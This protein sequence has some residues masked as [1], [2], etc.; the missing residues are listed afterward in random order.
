MAATKTAAEQKS[1]HEDWACYCC[2][3]PLGL[4]EAL[5]DVAG[6]EGNRDTYMLCD[7]CGDV[8]REKIETM[9]R[10]RTRT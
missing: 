10:L 2:I 3:S 1:F 5:F 6:G 7:R 4:R 8:V 9:A